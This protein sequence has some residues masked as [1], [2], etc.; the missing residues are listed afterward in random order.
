MTGE[1]DEG[2][3]ARALGE[4]RWLALFIDIDGTLLGIAPTPDAVHVPPSLIALLER[5]VLGLDGAVALLTGRRIA[6]ADRLFAPLKLIAAGVH[7]TELRSERS[8]SIMMLAPPVSPASCRRSIALQ[9]SRP[10]F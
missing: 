7:G 6:D 4:R 3:G 10:A 5:L 2:P 1:R 8:G 9:R